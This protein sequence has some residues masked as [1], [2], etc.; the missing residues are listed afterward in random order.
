MQPDNSDGNRGTISVGTGI[1]NSDAVL[2]YSGDYRYDPSTGVLSAEISW[3]KY[4]EDGTQTVSEVKRVLGRLL[5]Y[6]GMV[7]FLCEFS[8]TETISPED[9]LPLTFVAGGL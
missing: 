9:V 5:S 2:S 7:H 1:P 4:N 8:D 3:K 6:G